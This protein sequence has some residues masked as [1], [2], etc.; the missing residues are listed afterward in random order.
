MSTMELDAAV[1]ESLTEQVEEFMAEVEENMND[2]DDTV[3]NWTFKTL[4]SF[5]DF[6]ISRSSTEDFL[7]QK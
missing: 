7:L 3:P 5:G 2:E 6:E 4:N 1:W